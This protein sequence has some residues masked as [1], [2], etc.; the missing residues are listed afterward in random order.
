MHKHILLEPVSFPS[1]LPAIPLTDTTSV[2]WTPVPLISPP[3]SLAPCQAGYWTCRCSSPR[4][5]PPSRLRT[6][7]HPRQLRERPGA[8]LSPPPPGWCDP[9][10]GGPCWSLLA[11]SRR[12]GPPL[13]RVLRGRGCRRWK[14]ESNYSGVIINLKKKNVTLRAAVWA[15][16]ADRLYILQPSTAARAAAWTAERTA[17]TSPLT[18]WQW[19]TSSYARQVGSGKTCLQNKSPQTFF[20]RNIFMW[21]LIF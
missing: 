5:P 11:V 13:L 7:S 3:E 15:L 14:G 12:A 4:Q 16:T 6:P 20:K 19:A 21:H 8:R 2:F 18:N 9:S 17:L 1:I 10:L